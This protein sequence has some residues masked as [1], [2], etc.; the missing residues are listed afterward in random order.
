M[1]KIKGLWKTCFKNKIVNIILIQSFKLT[2]TIEP[3]KK[4]WVWDGFSKMYRI[5][6]LCRSVF[7]LTTPTPARSINETSVYIVKCLT[8]KSSVLI[9]DLISCYFYYNGITSRDVLNQY[10]VKKGEQF[11]VPYSRNVT[12][13]TL[14]VWDYVE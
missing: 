2:S 8:K 4:N 11:P 5:R 14:P 12:N 13:Q 6:W 7:C 1:A 3:L 10:T 9:P